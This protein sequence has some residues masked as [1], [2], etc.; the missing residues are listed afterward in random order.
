M[1]VELRSL[2]LT[3]PQYAVLS[4]VENQPGISN[5]DLARAAFVTP[6]TTQGIIANLERD[7]LVVRAAD[8]KHGRIL[9]TKLTTK[10]RKVLERSHRV[11]GIIEKELVKGISEE[12]STN[13]LELLNRCAHNMLGPKI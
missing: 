13:L 2:G 6:Q 10:G 3:T 8:E 5:A 7:E 12:E 9:C 11:V 4:C 1:D